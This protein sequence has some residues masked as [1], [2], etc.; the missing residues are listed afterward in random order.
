MPRLSDSMEEATVLAVAEAAGR[1]GREGRAARRGRDRQGDDRLRGRASRRAGG[2]P[3]RRRRHGR[4]RRG[5]RPAARRGRRSGRCRTGARRRPRR[6][7][8]PPAAGARERRRAHRATPGRTAPRRAA[9]RPARGRRRNRARRPHR[10]RRRPR[11]RRPATGAPEPG[12]RG[13]GHVLELT[14]DPADDRAADERVARARSRSSRSR[15]RSTWRPPRACATSCA[16]AGREPLPSFN[17]LVVRAAA[18]A[19]REFP[20]LNASYEGDRC[21]RLLADQR[22]D[23]GRHRGRAHRAR[24][25]ATRTRSP[26]SSSPPSRVG[27]PRRCA[28]GRSAP[29]DLADGT[30]TVSNLGMFGVRRFTA[31]INH[32]QAAILAVGEVTRAPG[33][34]R[35]G[36]ARRAAA[37]GRQPLVRPPD[38]LR[39]RGGALPAAARV[40]CSRSPVAAGRREEED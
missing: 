1:R 38:R 30:F 4:A 15:R 13:D 35:R 8:R 21:P 20:R 16:A 39:R 27:S 10:P 29:D 5:D 22:R 25:S 23:R 40:A 11:A 12:G 33:R 14:A 36:R 32:P 3:R 2:G 17:D 37:D 24:R 6:L 26:C 34:D 28:R 31:V 18:L 19:L 9:R 7:P